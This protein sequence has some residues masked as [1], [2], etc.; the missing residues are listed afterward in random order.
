MI[1]EDEALNFIGSLP[2]GRLLKKVRPKEVTGVVVALA[3]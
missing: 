3:V 1:V 2:M